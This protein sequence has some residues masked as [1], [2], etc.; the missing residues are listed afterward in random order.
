MYD[1]E[2]IAE[3]HYGRMYDEY[4]DAFAAEDEDDEGSY[5]DGCWWEGYDD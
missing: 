1:L 2:A 3:R 5:L 4:W